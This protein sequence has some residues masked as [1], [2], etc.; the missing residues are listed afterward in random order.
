MNT[1]VYYD[2]IPYGLGVSKNRQMTVCFPLNPEATGVSSRFTDR[3]LS[4]NYGDG[5][6]FCSTVDGHP[7]GVYI[8]PSVMDIDQF[9]IVRVSNTV[10]ER[11]DGPR[12]RRYE[13]IVNKNSNDDY[14]IT[15]IQDDWYYG[16][17]P[18][19]WQQTYTNVVSTGWYPIR[20]VGWEAGVF[21]F[22]QNEY[23]TFQA[24]VSLKIYLAPYATLWST[25]YVDAV[26]KI[27]AI[28]VNAV[29]GILDLFDFLRGLYSALR[30]P[31][32]ALH[33]AIHS[34]KDWG[35]DW[36]SYRYVYTTTKLDISE[37][38]SGMKAISEINN[39]TKEEYSVTGRA[40]DG[41]ISVGVK[42]TFKMCDLIPKSYEEL[43]RQY[44]LVPSAYDLWDIIPFSFM[45]DW[46]AQL[47]DILE[48]FGKFSNT[49]R[50]RPTQT[51]FTA[52]TVYQNQR[53][54]FRVEGTRL[55]IPPKLEFREVSNKTLAMRITDFVAIFKP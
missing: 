45:V 10:I 54:F 30:D 23:E 18:Y 1:I 26:D 24:A 35:N 55:S 46:F 40:K 51:W 2:A 36:L 13:W 39:L 14:D 17:G 48:N 19:R 50:F 34:I 15:A 4:P 25:A 7:T 53:T 20:S 42:V 27:P 29:E 5:P 44:G 37:I 22:L 21:N 3:G 32:S 52:V 49:L 9:H 16:D 47:G 41:Q 8:S 12:R 28:S 31:I 6:Y 11:T 33:D 43:F 38:I